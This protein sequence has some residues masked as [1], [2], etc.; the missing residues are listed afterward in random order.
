MPRIHT[1]NIEPSQPIGKRVASFVEE[2]LGK[3]IGFRS[4][5]HGAIDATTA[6]GVLM[7]HIFSSLAQF[8]RRL[9]QERTTPAWPLPAHVDGWAAAGRCVPMIP[10]SSPSSACTRTAA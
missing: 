9:V 10:A 2:L 8:E 6:S 4:L 7:S 5:L 1:N 3:G